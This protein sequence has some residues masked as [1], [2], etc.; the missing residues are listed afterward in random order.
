MF[1]TKITSNTEHRETVKPYYKSTTLQ[2]SSKKTIQA[3]NTGIRWILLSI[4]KFNPSFLKRFQTVPVSMR[5][6]A[7][8]F[9]SSSYIE[10][11]LFS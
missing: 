11:M 7:S 9:R 6:D 2:I 3:N 10:Y 4:S 8:K 1:K 5:T